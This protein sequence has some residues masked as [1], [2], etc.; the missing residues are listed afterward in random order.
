M[1][2]TKII[3][4]DSILLSTRATI[5]VIAI[6]KVQL[7]ADRGF[8]VIVIKDKE[9]I[10]PRYVAHVLSGKVDEMKCK[11]LGG[12]F[13]EIPKTGLKTIQI[14][15]PPIEVQREIVAEIDRYQKIVD[16]LNHEIQ[17]TQDHINNAI[18]EIL[19]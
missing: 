7:I 19:D 1:S 9:A 12:T 18:R 6:N 10:S 13:K 14:P 11:S 8:K 5:G 3:P 4:P 17:E 16:N 15:L 2:G